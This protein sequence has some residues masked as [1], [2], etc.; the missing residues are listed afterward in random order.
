MQGL[1]ARRRPPAAIFAAGISHPT[2]TVMQHAT[3][4][5]TMSRSHLQGFGCQPRV[6]RFGGGPPHHS[7]APQ[8]QHHRHI[9]PAFRRPDIGQIR[10]PRLVWAPWAQTP[11]P[12]GSER[13]AR[14]DRFAWCVA[15]TVGRIYL[16]N[17]RLASA[18]RCVCSH[19]GR[20]GRPVPA[21]CA[22]RHTAPGAAHARCGF[23]AATPRRCVPAGWPRL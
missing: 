8:I 19:A 14:R 21:G 10:D 6:Q 7:P 13:W 4:W 5:L 12:A 9:Q 23:S 15:Q 22:E 3:R 2:I 18:G 1:H 20:P 17:L 11:G 16:G